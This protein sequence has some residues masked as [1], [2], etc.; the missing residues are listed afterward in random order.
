MD[1]V[2]NAMLQKFRDQDMGVG[3]RI[4]DFGYW[5]SDIGHF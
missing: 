2:E 1:L 4:L 3:F 5:I